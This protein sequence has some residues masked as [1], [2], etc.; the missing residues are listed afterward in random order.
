M[1]KH[2][3]AENVN[4]NIINTKQFKDVTISIRFLNDV[5]K[6]NNPIRYILSTFLSTR[7]KD[8]PTK[9]SF[10]NKLASLFGAQVTENNNLNGKAH[11][12]E[13]SLSVINEIFS[14]TKLLESQF[15]LLSSMIFNPLLDDEDYFI[16]IKNM[17]I[18]Q[19]QSYQ[20]DISFYSSNKAK[21][22]YNDILKLKSLPTVEQINMISQEEVKKEYLKM[23]NE[24]IINIFVLGDIDE[25]KIIK[26]TTKYFPFSDR[27]QDNFCVTQYATRNKFD[28]VNEYLDTNQSHLIMYYELHRNI[29]NNDYYASVVAN[30]IFGL[31][32][33]SFLFQEVREKRSLCY[34]IYSTNDNFDG[35]L[36]VKTAVD[37]SKIDE[38]IKLIEQQ[39]I[40]VK[41]QE[42]TDEHLESVKMT[43]V[44]SINGVYDNKHTLIDFY[45]NNILS[46]IDR[47]VNDIIEAIN[48]VTK[49]DVVTSFK[50]IELKLIYS[51]MNK[52][53]N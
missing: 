42:F 16:E 33:S 32:P 22:N 21:E 8:F 40:K 17:L 51:L 47:E 37:R 43:L 39:L 31:L 26:Y 1:I 25:D 13:L 5:S 35:I 46:K 50:D 48:K 12:I 30:A 23:I 4:L 14:D 19:V 7:C 52:E 53:D 27:K 15:Q 49:N 29:T 28:R 2:Q 36:K 44:N 34:S 3:I 18:L 11:S 10:T 20:D 41:N 45:Y 38:T 6:C 24:E 9:L